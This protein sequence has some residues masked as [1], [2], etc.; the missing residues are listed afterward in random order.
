[1]APPLRL[2][3]HPRRPRRAVTKVPQAKYN[4]VKALLALRLRQLELGKGGA[5]APGERR[6]LGS[7]SEVVGCAQRDLRRY[8]LP[9]SC[10]ATSCRARRSRAAA[11]AGGRARARARARDAWAAGPSKVASKAGRAACSAD[12]EGR[13]GG[14]GRPLRRERH[15]AAAGRGAVGPRGDRRSGS[16]W[17]GR[18][19]H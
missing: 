13:A 3:P 7:A 11:L 16:V 15:R 12:G 4:N 5:P 2:R 9:T 14:G 6:E 1:L 18:G 17:S 19:G 10:A 8:L